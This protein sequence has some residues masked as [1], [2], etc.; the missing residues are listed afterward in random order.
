MQVKKPSNTRPSQASLGP[1]GALGAGAAGAGAGAGAAV[2]AGAG[3]AAGGGGVGTDGDTGALGL[4]AGTEAG[5]LALRAGSAA[6]R[7]EAARAAAEAAREGAEA[8]AAVALAVTVGATLIVVV[9]ATL[10]TVLVEEVGPDAVTVAVGV[11]VAASV[12]AGA[13]DRVKANK[14]APTAT[15]PMPAIAHTLEDTPP[16]FSERGKGLGMV[17]AGASPPAEPPA[18]FSMRP[19]SV[20]GNCV[21]ANCVLGPYSESL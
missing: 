10:L 18:I 6:L 11:G 13:G 12:E 4:L 17:S 20:D 2:G 14:A 8:A 9:A 7:A 15:I 3:D 21:A 16:D 19:G 1:N 5:A